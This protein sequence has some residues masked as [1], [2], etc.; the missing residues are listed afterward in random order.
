MLQAKLTD[1]KADPACTA[2]CAGGSGD[3]GDTSEW[4]PG[5]ADL[6]SAECGRVFEPFWDQCGRMLTNAG[7]GGMGEMSIF[8][9]PCPHAE[10]FRLLTSRGT[11][12]L[13]D[14]HCLETLY[15]PGICGTF[16]N[17]HT[18]ECYVAEVHESCCDEDGFNCPENRDIPRTCPVGW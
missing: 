7:M 10:P 14:D 16:C 6:C 5:R 13:P 3:C 12:I 9:E 11:F 1:I 2:G 4:Y 17:E 15:P 8:C 18:Y